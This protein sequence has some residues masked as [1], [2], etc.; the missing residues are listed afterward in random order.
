MTQ[1]CFQSTT[2]KGDEQMLLETRKW[3]PEKPDRIVCIHGL[4]QHAGV[5][6]PLGE[7]LAT[8]GHSVLAVTLRGHGDSGSEPPW[9]TG[10]HAEDVLETVEE[11]GVERAHWVGHSFG[12]RVA[13]T[14][15]AAQPER[16]LGV[17]LLEAPA[18]IAPERALRAIEIERLD[19]SFATV[20][21][22]TEAMLAS[23]LMSAPPRDLVA[24]FVKDDVRRGADGRFRFRFS[25][26]AAVVAW[27]EMTLPPPPIAK[28]PTLLV[29]A[30][31]PL[32]DT[33]ERDRE[34]G[35][36]LGELQTRVEV[37]HGHNVLWESPG[38]TLGAVEDFVTRTTSPVAS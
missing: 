25:P 6:E 8:A 18:K 10:T 21:G 35:E 27:S 16:T 33:G 37:P 14:L 5:F 30:A 3:G 15:V 32:M 28:V 31:K 23:E 12:G 17:A 19:W 7:R 26:G 24:A 4:T 11:A 2:T 22:A 34:Y 20:E 38:E 36:E 13:A 29:C 9:N 1:R